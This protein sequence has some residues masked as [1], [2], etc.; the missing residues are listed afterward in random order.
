MNNYK[1]EQ[2]HFWAGN[3]GNDY[4]ERNKDREIIASNTSLFSNVIKDTVGIK[5]VI[6]FGAN[7]GL[8]LIAI[9]NI[10]PNVVISGVEINEKAFSGLIKIC[11][12][13]N[14]YH[15]SI[16]DFNID[17][18]RDLVLIKGVLIHINPEYLQKVYELLYASSNKYICIAEYYNPTPV[19]ISYR[20]VKDKLFKRDFAGEMMDKYKD[21]TLKNYGFICHRDNNFAAD[22]IT[23]FLLEKSNF[24]T[25][26]A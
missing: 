23:W 19:T 3:F 24:T 18:Q 22:D 25:K 9:K 13:K 6:E 26:N 5:T 2:E 10:S 7:I 1:T 21:L 12:D 8:N 15:K 11:G 17:Y 20:G 16:L 14:A 4:I